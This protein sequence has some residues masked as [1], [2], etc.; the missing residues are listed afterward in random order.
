MPFRSHPRRRH[1]LLAALATAF[2][3]STLLASASFAADPAAEP[4]PL[5]SPSVAA[6]PGIP[7]KGWLYARSGSTE[8][9]SRLSA[10]ETQIALDDF[11]VFQAFVRTHFPEASFASDWPML[12]ILCDSTWTFQAFGGQEFRVTGALPETS[13]FILVDGAESAS[14]ERSIRRRYVSLAFE[15]HA[16]GRYPLWFRIGLRELLGQVRITREHIEFGPV[17]PTTFGPGPMIDFG[18]MLAL[19]PDSPE[20]ELLPNGFTGPAHRQAV[21]FTHMCLFGT[22]PAH[23]ALREPFTRFLARL[24][25]EPLSE[26]LFYECFDMGYA[27]MHAV[28]RGYMNGTGLSRYDMRR[29]RFKPQPPVSVSPAAPE[30]V[31]SVLEASQILRTLGT[32]A[33]GEATH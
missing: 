24:Q 31:L 14:V 27:D 13:N 26:Q 2:A 30:V 33:P 20:Q 23:R 12:V 8:V 32:A 22:A 6:R 5:V 15:Q 16:E 11:L 21:L 4:P 19:T 25:R 9:L 17:A 7:T 28:L 29:Y 1:P 3:A 18:R 10:K